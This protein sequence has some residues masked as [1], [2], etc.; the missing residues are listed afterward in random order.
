[1]LLLEGYF[2]VAFDVLCDHVEVLLNITGFRFGFECLGKH[3][4]AV[5]ASTELKEKHYLLVR[6]T[7]FVNV[8]L[9]FQKT[10]LEPVGRSMLSSACNDSAFGGLCC[11]VGADD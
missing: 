8:F 1:M 9:N 2:T 7:G 4:V 11:Q 5:G 6:L 3:A 10:I